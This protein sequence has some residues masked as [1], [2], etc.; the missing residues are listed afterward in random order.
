MGSNVTVARLYLLNS[1]HRVASLPALSQT[2]IMPPQPWFCWEVNKC[3]LQPCP[4]CANDPP[5]SATP[6]CNLSWYVLGISVFQS[7]L[8]TLFTLNQ[9]PDP[10]CPNCNG[11][12]VE[13][14]S[15][16]KLCACP[17]SIVTRPFQID[18][19][20]N[21]PR[22]FQPDHPN[23]HEHDHE[24]PHDHPQFVDPLQML[25]MIIGGM[26]AP[27][28]NPTGGPSQRSGPTAT[29]QDAPDGRSRGFTFAYSSG[30]P[31]S[32]D[33]LD[34]MDGIFPPSCVMIFRFLNRFSI[35]TLFKA[36][37]NPWPGKLETRMLAT[38]M[39][40]HRI[41][42]AAMAPIVTSMLCFT[43]VS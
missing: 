28:G 36:F 43:S 16:S 31:L 11:S 2:S 35:F 14:V 29:R 27:A 20:E 15:C 9:V 21:D 17:A 33:E 23:H 8:T 3:L 7:S 22:S 13:M 25:S 1:N 12:F 38:V 30:E 32:P 37:C 26:R 41:T 19:P 24:H 40:S 18:N 42:M 6:K 34:A 39:V 10:H 5:C 4:A